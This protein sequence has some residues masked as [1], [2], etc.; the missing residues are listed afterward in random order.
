MIK[1]PENYL[2]TTEISYKEQ[3]LAFFFFFIF[4]SNVYSEVGAGKTGTENLVNCLNTQVVL[5]CKRKTNRFIKR[6]TVYQL[7]KHVFM[8]G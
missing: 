1:S 8:T 6:P 7:C 5:N 3:T 4:P 2:V